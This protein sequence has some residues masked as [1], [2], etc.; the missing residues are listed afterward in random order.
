MQKH[1][2]QRLYLSAKLLLWALAVDMVLVIDHIKIFETAIS[3]LFAMFF[4]LNIEYQ[5]EGATLMESTQR[6]V[7]QG[8]L[9]I[10]KEC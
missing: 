1:I 8:N 10:I 6:W 9:I 4:I 5:A 3:I 7:P 2:L